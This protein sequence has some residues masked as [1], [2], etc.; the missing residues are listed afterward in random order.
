MGRT[1]IKYFLL[2]ATLSGCFVAF[3]QTKKTKQPV[4]KETDDSLNRTDDRKQK[5]GTWFYKREALRGEPAYSEFGNYKDD[6]KTGHWIKLD[7][8][9]RLVSI[10][11][12]TRGA[13][14]GESQ[15]YENGKLICIGHYRGLNPDNKVDSIWVTDPLTYEEV[16][17]MVPTERGSMKH[18]LWRYYDPNTGQLTREEEYQ[19]DD[20]IFTKDF[21]FTATTDSTRLKKRIENMPHNKKGKTSERKVKSNIY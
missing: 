7:G 6:R 17:V 16:L 8:E 9:N 21:Q 19:I 1:S 12:Y 13:L 18:G 14:N 15:Y 11:N 4:K 20:L 5:Q 2:I 10:E 3:A